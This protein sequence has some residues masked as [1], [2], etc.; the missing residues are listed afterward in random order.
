MNSLFTFLSV[1]SAVILAGAY[2]SWRLYIKPYPPTEDPLT[3]EPMPPQPPVEPNLPP[4]SPPQPEPT[5]V[6]PTAPEVLL[7]ATPKQ[8]WHSARVLCDRAGL[9]L[10]EKN[11]ICG[12][13]YQES[14]FVATATHNNGKTIDYG[15]CQFNNGKNKQGIPYWI[16]P[17]ALFSSVQDVFNNSARQVNTMIG[18]YKRGEMDLWSSWK[19][20]EYR[21]WLSIESRMWDLAR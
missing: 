1:M 13:I 15:L 21:Q 17:G 3:P 11:D 20:G 5:P 14:R 12:V 7:W 8:A 18:C 16:G 10:K 9:S 6:L 19:S 2:T 4:P